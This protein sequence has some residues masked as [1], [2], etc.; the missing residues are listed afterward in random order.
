MGINY[1]QKC[2]LGFIIEEEKIGKEISPAVIEEQPRYD[3]KTGK[4]EKYEKI[5]VKYAEYSYEFLGY[6]CEDFYDLY[7]ELVE[8][9]EN[10][11]E[12][13]IQVEIIYDGKQQF[14]SIGRNLIETNDY[15]RASLIDGILTI[16]ELL[17]HQKQL[18]EI[19]PDQ[20][21]ALH[22]STSVG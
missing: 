13:N 14:I 6:V 22:F 1:E 15:G 8:H 7:E 11:P 18:K 17:E 5:I 16:E 3:P 12:L 10:L 19:F 2:M 20:E 4:I 9:F 21:I